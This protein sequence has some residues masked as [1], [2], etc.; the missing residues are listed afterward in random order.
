MGSEPLITYQQLLSGGIRSSTNSWR[1]VLDAN[2]D[3][4]TR[5][6]VIAAATGNAASGSDSR[7]LASARKE[8]GRPSCEAGRC[9][10][11][12]RDDARR[13]RSNCSAYA[14]SHALRSTQCDRSFC[15]ALAKNR[16][17]S[18][19]TPALNSPPPEETSRQSRHRR[20]C[21]AAR[22]EVGHEGRAGRCR[23]GAGRQPQRKACRQG[24]SSS[25]SASMPPKRS[26]AWVAK[27]ARTVVPALAGQDAP[28]SSTDPPSS[29]P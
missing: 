7:H 22:R 29:K 4:W 23:E 9:A 3:D 6:A 20:R 17:E 1:H 2:A 28:Q 14:Q 5:S 18:P 19:A 15:L 12:A 11:G 16:A 10:R 24:R 25:T 26:S 8:L 21:S 27:L 13:C